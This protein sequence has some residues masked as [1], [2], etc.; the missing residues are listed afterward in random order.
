MQSDA[1]KM[2]WGAV[3]KG[4]KIGGQWTS[5]KATRH[6]NI[7]ELEAV[8]FALKSFVEFTTSSHIQLQLDNSTTAAY[9]N[10]VGVGGSNSLGLGHPARELAISHPYCWNNQL[11]G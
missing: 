11:K 1:S 5:T 6:I 9:L 8:F 2:S 7:L 3:V 4:Q 10:N